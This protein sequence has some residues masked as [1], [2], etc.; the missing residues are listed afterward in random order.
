MEKVD[1][2]NQRMYCQFRAFP[3]LIKEGIRIGEA[4]SA[5]PAKLRRI[6]WIGMGASAI[7]GEYVEAYFEEKFGIEF[8][9]SRIHR[10]AIFPHDDFWIFYSYSGNTSETIVAFNYVSAKMPND[11]IIAVSS[12]GLLEKEAKKKGVK[13]V[14]LKAGFVSRTHIPMGIAAISIIIGKILGNAQLI[15]EDLQKCADF[16]EKFMTKLERKAD[17]IAKEVSD[18]KMPILIAPYMFHPV[19]SYFEKTLN[20]NTKRPA[21]TMILPEG[22]HNT[23]CIFENYA[24]K[25]MAILLEWNNG[26]DLCNA[27]LRAFKRIASKFN[28]QT[29]SVKIPCNDFSFV[30]LLL[31]T[32]FV[33]FLSVKLANKYHVDSYETKLILE[34]KNFVKECVKNI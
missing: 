20:E 9:I 14:K 3:E 27:Y 26:D 24:S 1:E 13:H 11:K 33:G 17:E 12:G 7:V 18:D 22:L 15:H 8:R 28:I 16:I 30:T 31:P 4:F 23:I 5:E 10:V 19:L 29:F 32:V 2:N 34:A 21:L 25:L 6:H